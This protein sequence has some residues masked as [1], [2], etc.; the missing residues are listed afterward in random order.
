MNVGLLETIFP[1]TERKQIYTQPIVA[2]PTDGSQSPGNT[3]EALNPATGK[4]T[5]IIR[6]R[7]AKP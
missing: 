3:V 5:Q 6:T 1:A 4:A 7:R 2:E